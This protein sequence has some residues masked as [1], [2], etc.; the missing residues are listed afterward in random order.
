MSEFDVFLCHN[1]QDKPEVK[2]IARQLQQE[3][4]KPWLDEW[5]LRPGLSWQEL[6]EEQIEDI[7]TAAVFVGSSGLGPWQKREM[8]AFL[9]EFVDRGCPVIPVLLENAPQKPKLPIFLKA[10]TWVDFRRRESNPMGKLVWGV[11]GNKPVDFNTPISETVTPEKGQAQSFTEDL[12]ND[13]TLEM[14]SIPGGSFMMGSPSGE[15]YR[16]EKPQHQVSIPKF[17]MGKYPITQAQYKQAIA[18]NPSYFQGDDC[19]DYCPVERVSWQDAEEFCQRLSR[20]TGKKY[21]LPT[22][23]EWEYACRAGTTTPYHFGQAITDKLA[24]YDNNVGRTTSVGQFPP[25]VFGLYD[26]HGNVW[27][28]CQD[29]WHDNY[30]GAPT[31]GSPWLSENSSNKVIRGGS[32]LLN[33]GVCRSAF[34]NS[35]TRDFRDHL[36]GF[37]VVC[38][39]PGTT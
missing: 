20:Q 30:E 8:R 7:K 35:R 6:L 25:N 9:S 31:D 26:M 18:K 37:R 10:M 16:S 22:E 2:K 13:I 12:G 34:R 36:I 5:E 21:R 29:D 23:A 4:L 24:N 17:F 19:D 15:G 38:V 14:V 33:P 11:T 28:W 3:G 27:E 32:W 39:A 1:S